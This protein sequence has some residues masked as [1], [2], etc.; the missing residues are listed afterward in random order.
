MAVAQSRKDAKTQRRPGRKCRL[1]SLHFAP[2]RL[3]AFASILWAAF[4]VESVTAQPPDEPPGRWQFETLTLK[5]AAQVRGLIQGETYAEFDFAQIIQ[6]PGKPMFAV[7]RG[8]PRDQVDQIERLAAEEHVKLVQRF[9]LFRNRAVIEAGRMDALKLTRETDGGAARLHYAGR[10]FH[11]VSS[12]NDEQTRRCLVRIEQLFRAYRTLLPPHIDQPHALSVHLFGS[13]DEYRGRLRELE[14][15]LDNAAFYSP[16]QA[17]IFAA[18]DLNLF[19]DRLAHV[20]RE[21]ERVRKEIARLDAEHGKRLA[22]LPQELRTAGFSADEAAAEI[23]QRKATWKKELETTLAANRERERAAEQ[24]FA[25]VTERMFA[26]LAHES[27]H[28][29]LDTYVYPHDRHHVP[30]WLNEGLAQVFES[31]Q[32]D[33]DSLRL[34]APDKGRLAA[35]R[36]ELASSR[37]LPLAQVLAANEREFLGPHASGTPERQYLYAWGLAHYLVFH[38][39]L[40]ASGRLDAFVAARSQRLEPIAR[41]E[42]LVGRSL[43]EF[44]KAWREAML[45][46]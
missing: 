39:N 33:G 17:T 40:L 1:H 35:L 31:G 21:H 37:P 18:S 10:W 2:L 29:W 15:E 16:R 12:A 23:R 27:F 44:E 7:V 14:L 24:K 6:P 42:Q 3:C 4:K 28:A 43:P 19:A 25:A 38:E 5:D 45:R 41:F 22:M 30:R 11:L 32:L 9:A 8:I 36:A 34:D 26:S 13:Q 46:P 20:R